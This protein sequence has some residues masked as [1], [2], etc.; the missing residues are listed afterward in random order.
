[1]SVWLIREGLRV[2]IASASSCYYC[3]ITITAGRPKLRFK[4]V[5]NRDMKR[6]NINSNSWESIADDRPS[7]SQTVKQGAKFAEEALTTAA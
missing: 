2:P 5:C 6:C 3:I 4:D 7:W 1:M